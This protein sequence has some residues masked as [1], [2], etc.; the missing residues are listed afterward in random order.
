MRNP[1]VP[2]F[3]S[4]PPVLAGRDRR[5]LVIE[6]GEAF[7]DAPGHPE[8]AAIFA[9]LRGVGKTVLLSEV[10]REAQERGWLVIQL[11]ATT[12]SFLPQ[13][14][15]YCAAI[16]ADI[17]A[18]APKRIL[19]GVKAFGIELS[20]SPLPQPPADF[21]LRGAITEICLWLREHEAGLLITVDEIHG[22]TRDEIRLFGAI[23][24]HVGQR[25]GL[26]LAFAAA[27]YPS[28]VEESARDNQATFLQRCSWHE[29]ASIDPRDVRAAFR[30]TIE[31]AGGTIDAAALERVATAIGGY[32]YMFQLAGYS[33]WRRAE[34]VRA[35]GIADVEAGIV[36]ARTKMGRSLFEPMWRE[37][38]ELARRF[39]IA[40]ALHDEDE[41][42]VAVIQKAL[43][44]TPQ[45]VNDY[46]AQLIGAGWLQQVRRG[47]V[48]LR[49][50]SS[51]E[52]LRDRAAPDR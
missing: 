46:R 18:P 23:F 34:E 41:V 44:R 27:G 5:E 4:R 31:Q 11:D 52:W 47:V 13:L 20:A 3:G 35:I 17:H 37:T 9:G 33:T 8:R 19:T 32:A 39:L 16:L 2:T 28:F 48:R 10:Q 36:D 25:D 21:D 51:K 29:I 14:N 38:S 24:Q 15:R 30:E 50:W 49:H 6:V 7:D 26:P 12:G 42:G 22:A 1:F 45:L 40:V 43:D